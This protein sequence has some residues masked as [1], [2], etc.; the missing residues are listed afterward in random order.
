M[1][2]HVKNKIRMEGI[3]KLPLFG[4]AENG[5]KFFDF[6]KL[7]PMPESLNVTS[8]SIENDAIAALIQELS[9]RTRFLPIAVK[10]K[11]GV[12]DEKYRDPVKKKELLE[13]GLQYAQNIVR[14][15]SSSWYE[16]CCKHWGTKW[17]AYELKIID[18]D[19]IS[20]ET[21]WSNPE[22][23][24]L[25]LADMYPESEIEHLW[26]DEDIGSNTGFREYRDG[27]WSEC[28][29]DACSDQAYERFIECWGE[30]NCLYKDET[31]TWKR[32]SCEDCTGCD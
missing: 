21:A 1:P 20:F 16:W 13:A 24:I 12:L 18:D 2:N 23:V 8:G 22:P 30:N 15:G 14:Y 3:A 26:A 17:N 5:E 4:E 9:N 11:D 10:V 19:T 27:E 7:I 31:G 6:N 32:H 28:Q 29:D 25:K